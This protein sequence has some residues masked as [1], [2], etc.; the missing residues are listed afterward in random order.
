MDG[1]DVVTSDEK[2]AGTVA[3]E[4]GGCL[5]VEHGALRKSRFAL[6]REFAHRCDGFV[7]ALVSKEILLSA[8][9]ADDEGNLDRHAVARHYGLETEAGAV[10]EPLGAERDAQA[11]GVESAE[12]ERAKIREALSERPGAGLPESPALLGERYK[13]V[14][15]P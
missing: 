1:W 5:L 13:H 4:S 8:P 2:K 7:R 12:H 15:E 6:P 9:T 11:A 3:G 10:D 14:R